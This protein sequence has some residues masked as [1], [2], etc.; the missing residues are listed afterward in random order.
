V[1]FTNNDSKSRPVV[2]ALYLDGVSV[3]NQI[4]RARNTV[5]FVGFPS[6][7]STFK[8]FVFREHI[9]RIA[10]AQPSPAQRNAPPPSAAAKQADAGSD[11]ETPVG[12]IWVEVYEWIQEQGAK[13]VPSKGSTVNPI[14]SKAP[15][16]PKKVP[17]VAGASDST[18]RISTQT[19]K[20]EWGEK[21]DVIG[22]R[23]NLLGKPTASA[24]L[25][26]FET[27]SYRSEED[28]D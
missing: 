23:Y 15:L 24:T 8:E 27:Q 12:Q 16:G 28:R 7:A 9:E 1:T 3:M 19:V 17:V 13:A 6:G 21:L 11:G 14:D 18:I 26:H 4:A 10:P 20:G 2:A 22:V 5:S 25:D